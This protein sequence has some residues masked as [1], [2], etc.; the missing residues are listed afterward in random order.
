M[1]AKTKCMVDIN[2]EFVSGLK[3]TVIMKRYLSEYPFLRPLTI[4]VKYYLKFC[5][6]NDPYTGGIGSY[7][8][9]V[10]IL[11]FLQNHTKSKGKLKEA[12][13]K[14]NLATILIDFFQYYG[15][16]FD[17]SKYVVS[18]LN[19]GAY[20]LKEDKNWKYEN[21]PDS[22]AI[23]DP[24][25]PDNDLGKASFN[26]KQIKLAFQHAYYVLTNPNITAPNNSMISKLIFIPHQIVF[27]RDEIKRLY[28]S[29]SSNQQCEKENTYYFE[30]DSFKGDTKEENSNKEIEN[31]DN[32][33]K[34]M[35]FSYYN[36]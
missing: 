1:D 12:T 20:L 26:I 31:I 9:L 33:S 23:E 32:T 11:S 36:I 28:S 17:Y 18:V 29:H 27:Y 16:L 14:E 22:L 30:N 10:L 7:S 19:N 24:E 4:I 5:L 3:N 35:F 6:L 15:I 2:F 34:S 21:F 8:L 13:E 25:N